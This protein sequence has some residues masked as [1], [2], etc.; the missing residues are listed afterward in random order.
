MTLPPGACH[1]AIVSGTNATTGVALVEAYDLDRTVDSK[2]ANIST[3]GLVERGQCHDQGFAPR[4]GA[5]PL[6]VLVRAI[7]PSLSVA[8]TLAN[9]TLELHDANGLL[10]A[11]NDNWRSDQEAEIIAFTIPPTD[12]L[13]SAIVMTLPSAAYTM[14][15]S[16]R[17][18]LHHR[19]RQRLEVHA[20]Q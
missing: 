4:S 19:R 14:Q 3:R 8:G 10:L 2:L 9:P 1:T 6:K 5:D 13:E 18:E 20:L 15:L 12:D 17:S 7:G 11:S 16:A